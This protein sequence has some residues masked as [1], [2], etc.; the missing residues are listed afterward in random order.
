MRKTIE[1]ILS[2]YKNCTADIIRLLKIDDFDSL[3]GEMQRRQ[4]IL[5]ELLSR[6][7]KND[8]AK[9]VYEKL[10]IKEIEDATQEL[11]KKKA[12]LIKKKLKDIS[13]NKAA[14]SAYGNLE[15]SAKIFSKKI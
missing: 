3:Q 13:K 7:D 1:E 5:N 8:E 6:T 4:C 9:G 12:F 10:N 14:S 15:N 2:D 11:M